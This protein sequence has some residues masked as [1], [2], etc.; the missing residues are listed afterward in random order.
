MNIY[1]R[2]KRLNI[3]NKLGVIGAIASIIGLVIGFWPGNKKSQHIEIHGDV[4]NSQIIQIQDSDGA[5]FQKIISD[6]EADNKKLEAIVKKLE[7]VEAFI[8]KREIER[9]SSYFPSGYKK[10]TYIVGPTNL[11][12]KLKEVFLFINRNFSK[13]ITGKLGLI[14]VEMTLEKLGMK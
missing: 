11:S 3:W 4:E 12:K 9:I 10:E 2:F 5:E 1:E 13:Q 7:S 6:I 8:L 14:G